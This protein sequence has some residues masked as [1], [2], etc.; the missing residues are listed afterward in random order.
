MNP[1]TN[2]NRLLLSSEEAGQLFGKSGRQWRRWVENNK[3]PPPVNAPGHPMWRRSDIELWVDVG[4]SM[5]AFRLHKQK[6]AEKR[7]A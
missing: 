2:S 4:C 3:A 7:K 5:T 1:S 6:L